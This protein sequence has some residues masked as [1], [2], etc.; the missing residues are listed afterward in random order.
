MKKTLVGI[1]ALVLLAAGT[2]TASAASNTN[3][4]SGTC[5]NGATWTLTQT[6]Q[7]TKVTTA[8]T[9]KPL[10]KGSQWNINYAY[11]N[12]YQVT[13]FAAKADSKGV[14]KFSHTITSANP[15]Y[16]IVMVDAWAP[17]GA[18]TCIAGSTL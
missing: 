15:V 7:G 1:A 2:L 16:A 18:T 14:L 5:Y 12:T 13:N 11:P 6:R 17:A 4:T 10:V 9:V 3:K 8:L